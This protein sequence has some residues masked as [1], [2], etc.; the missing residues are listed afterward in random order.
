MKIS[1]TFFYIFRDPRNF[2]VYKKIDH[3]LHTYIHII[4]TELL[5]LTKIL[6]IPGKVIKFRDLNP[7]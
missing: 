4:F 3:F 7:L 2:W 6:E 1:V 5:N